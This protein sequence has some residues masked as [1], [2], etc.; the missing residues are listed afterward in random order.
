MNG[1]GTGWSVFPHILIDK[2]TERAS[3]PALITS[4]RTVSYSELRTMILRI[5]SALRD[6]G[7][8]RGSHGDG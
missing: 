8:G 7:A 4:D 2:F 6:A 3:E 5:A 1:K